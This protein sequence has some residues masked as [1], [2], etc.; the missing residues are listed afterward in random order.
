MPT[1]AKAAP[2][3]SQEPGSIAGCPHVTGGDTSIQAL[4]YWLPG[5]ASERSWNWKHKLGSH[6]GCKHSRWCF[7]CYVKCLPSNISFCFKIR[8]VMACIV[9]SY[10]KPPPVMLTC[11]IRLLSMLFFFFL[12][13]YN[14]FTWMS[15]LQT[16]GKTENDILH[17]LVHPL[18][19]WSQKPGAFS[20][21][22]LRW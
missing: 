22:P 12:R 20:S 11:R 6:V 5:N 9:A 7:H 10:V 3:Q 21:L 16:K 19:G 8:S 18:D 4:I 13:P 14:L 2:C 15:E 1:L 17:L